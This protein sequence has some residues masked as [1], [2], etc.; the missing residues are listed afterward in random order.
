M[1]G[2]V[3]S[4]H[5]NWDRQMCHGGIASLWKVVCT[6]TWQLNIY[7]L[8]KCATVHANSIISG[9]LTRSRLQVFNR[10]LPN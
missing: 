7:E 2:K 1:G 8:G 10:V 5:T 3:G 9:Y 6:P 4:S